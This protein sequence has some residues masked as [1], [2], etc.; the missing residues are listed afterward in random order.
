MCVCVGVIT[1]VIDVTKGSRLVCV[2]QFSLILCPSS[3]N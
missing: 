1:V 2:V 3:T